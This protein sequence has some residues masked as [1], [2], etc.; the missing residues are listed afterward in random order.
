MNGKRNRT[1][2]IIAI[3][4]MGVQKNGR[5]KVPHK[6]Q[7]M[8]FLPLDEET[9]TIASKR[10]E[11]LPE[12]VVCFGIIF[13]PN[14]F[15]LLFISLYFTVTFFCFLPRNANARRTLCCFV[16]VHVVFRSLTFT[17]CHDTPFSH[18]WQEVFQTSPN[19]WSPPVQKTGV[20]YI[21]GGFEVVCRQRRCCRQTK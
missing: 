4:I 18:R 20:C 19:H 13:T 11:A 14:T 12:V 8:S 15:D 21:F 1:T 17:A 3:S 5:G 9:M 6:S 10:Q 2:F 7:S 16:V